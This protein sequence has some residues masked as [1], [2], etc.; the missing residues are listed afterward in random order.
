MQSLIFSN[1]LLHA[2]HQKQCFYQT[3][4]FATVIGPDSLQ[5]KDQEVLP[6]S[7]CRSFDEFSDINENMHFCTARAGEQTGACIVSTKLCMFF[8]S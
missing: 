6:I 5:I 2:I 8:Y 4:P 3:L 7:A 1:L